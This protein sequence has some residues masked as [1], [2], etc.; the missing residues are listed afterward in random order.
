[1][2]LTQ[3]ATGIVKWFNNTKGFGFIT[4]DGSEKD[5]F[6]HYTGIT[7]TG[8]RT[9]NEGERVSFVIAQG[10]KGQEAREVQRL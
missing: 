1:M 3:Q 10:Q 8:Y 7:G 2:S 4:I 5:I 6:V 9:L